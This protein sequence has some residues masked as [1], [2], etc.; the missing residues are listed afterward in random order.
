MRNQVVMGA[1]RGLS[2]RLGLGA[3]GSQGGGLRQ[4]RASPRMLPPQLRNQNAELGGD[5]RHNGVGPLT[6]ENNM[7]RGHGARVRHGRPAVADAGHLHRR[8][9]Q[10]HGDLLARP[11]RARRQRVRHRRER[12]SATRIASACRTPR[13]RCARCRRRPTASPSSIVTTWRE[14]SSNWSATPAST[15]SSATRRRPRPTASSTRSR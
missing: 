1:L 4:R 6:G 9:P 2:A 3:R 12:R 8:Q 7:A 10:Q 13:T 15:T 5:R 14:G 11:A